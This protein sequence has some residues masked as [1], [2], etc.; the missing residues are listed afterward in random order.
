MAEVARTKKM[1]DAFVSA[2]VLTHSAHRLFFDMLIKD[3]VGLNDI[4]HVRMILTKALGAVTFLEGQLK[5]EADPNE[6]L[7]N[8]PYEKDPNANADRVVPGTDSTE[9]QQHNTGGPQEV[10]QVEEHFPKTGSEGE[11]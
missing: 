1:A 3:R 2:S 10:F 6:K 7:L 5:G 11:A 9:G 8:F 4:V